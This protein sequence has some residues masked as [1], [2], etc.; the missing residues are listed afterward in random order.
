MVVIVMSNLHPDLLKRYAQGNCT[1]KEQLE[2]EAWL[3]AEEAFPVQLPDGDE[4]IKAE[5]WSGLVEKARNHRQLRYRKNWLLGLAAA[6]AMII[7]GVIF[8]M[9]SYQDFRAGNSIALTRFTA[10]QGSVV[11][12]TLPDG[13]TA[14]LAGGSILEFP[15]RFVNNLRKVELINGEGFFDIQHNPKQPFVL[16]TGNTTIRVLGTRFNVNNT[17]QSKL[18]ITLTQ[19]SIAFSQTGATLTKTILKPGQQLIYNK[20]LSVIESLSKADT[21][22]VTSWTIGTLWFKHTPMREVLRRL[23]RHYGVSFTLH[24]QADL[25]VPLTG[26]FRGQPISRILHLIENSTHLKFS[27]ENSKQITVN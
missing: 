6:F 10:P 19:G 13:S 25:N 22:Y 12:L 11:K 3:E 26:K 16:N 9:H 2:I 4:S 8:Y 15:E 18:A 23:E 14:R 20:N 27:K 5:I 21:S 17:D 1:E 24:N 7:A